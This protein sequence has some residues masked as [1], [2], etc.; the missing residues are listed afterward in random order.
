M[1]SDK[2]ASPRKIPA[3]VVPGARTPAA[4]ILRPA[5]VI[6]QTQLRRADR[7]LN[8]IEREGEALSAS[9]D[10]LLRRVS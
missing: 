3:R 1:A 6:G 8:R 2:T 9:A 7:L 5:E 4:A 10:R